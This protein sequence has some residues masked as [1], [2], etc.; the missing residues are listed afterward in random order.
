M[1]RFRMFVWI[2][3]VVFQW[4]LFLFPETFFAELWRSFLPY[5][6]VG[7]LVLLFIYV[8]FLLFK[9]RQTRSVKIWLVVL[10]VLAWALCGYESYMRHSFYD[11]S[12]E[13]IWTETDDGLSFLYANIY[14]LNED[15]DDLLWVIGTY[16]PDVLLFVEYTQEHHDILTDEFIERYPFRSHVHP[17][18]AP[19]WKVIYSKYPLTD[20]SENIQDNTWRY[21]AVAI[22]YEGN[23]YTFYLVHTSS[24]NSP[25]LL[26]MRNQQLWDLFSDINFSGD[27]ISILWDFNMSPW[28]HTY[29]LFKQEIWPDFENMTRFLPGVM[30][31]SWN[32]KWVL[33]VHIDHVRTNNTAMRKYLTSLEIVWSD[34]KGFYGIVGE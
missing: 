25:W 31:R 10:F 17:Q 24:P 21:G 34:H 6:I 8:Y 5:W 1:H 13:S 2:L 27:R 9:K 28:S 7:A 4:A 23:V 18:Q 19:S 12:Y 26:A 3:F 33:S 11:E 20:I 15:I 30:T 16:D 32:A 14:R 22:S 29:S